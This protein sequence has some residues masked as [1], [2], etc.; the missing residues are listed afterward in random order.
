MSVFRFL[1]ILFLHVPSIFVG[2]SL[3]V[4]AWFITVVGYRWTIT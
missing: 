2:A 3:D 4:R 1:F